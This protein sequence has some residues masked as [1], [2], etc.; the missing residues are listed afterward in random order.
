MLTTGDCHDDIDRNT[1][2]IRSEFRESLALLVRK[3]PLDSDIAPISVAVFLQRF[4][5][6]FDPFLDRHA[7]TLEEKPEMGHLPRPGTACPGS[8]PHPASSPSPATPAPC[9]K[10][11]RLSPRCARAH[12]C[13]PR[14]ETDPAT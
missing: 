11:R 6:G 14:M 10:R 7:I 8:R 5:E 13:A 9:T 3:P 12:I 2:K 1:D 4:Q